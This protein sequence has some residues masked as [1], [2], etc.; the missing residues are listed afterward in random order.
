MKH[1]VDKNSINRR[2]FL[3]SFLVASQIFATIPVANAA[4]SDI[5]SAAAKNS[6][7][8]YSSNAKN[9]NR[10]SMGDGS[11][12]S[13]YDNSPKNPAAARRRAMT[14]CKIDSARREAGQGKMSERDC[15]LKVMDGDYEF[16]LEA[17]RKLDCPSC[18]YGVGDSVKKE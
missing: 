14:G 3:A 10:V 17:M 1:L 12:G 18:P 7:I 9:L 11:G 8:T 4:V 15:N 13:V 16:M 6:E 5:L 2:N